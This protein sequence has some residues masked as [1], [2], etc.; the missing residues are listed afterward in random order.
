MAVK[1]Y[2]IA[3]ISPLLAAT[4]YAL[5]VGSLGVLTSLLQIVK[6]T[7]YYLTSPGIQTPYPKFLGAVSLD[8]VVSVMFGAIVGWI[9]GLVVSLV[10][11]WWVK[12]TGGIKID[13]DD[14]N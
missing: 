3:R 10:Y 8:G 5:V 13:L 12:F 6:G 11:N 9:I 14:L 1:T 7:Y 4:L 2:K